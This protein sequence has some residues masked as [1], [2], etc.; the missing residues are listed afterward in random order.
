MFKWKSLQVE[1]S[2]SHKL[3]NQTFGFI[4]FLFSFFQSGSSVRAQAWHSTVWMLGNDSLLL[5]HENNT[6]SLCF[7]IQ[8]HAAIESILPAVGP[9]WR[10]VSSSVFYE[11]LEVEEHNFFASMRRL[12]KYLGLVY[13]CSLGWHQTSRSGLTDVRVQNILKAPE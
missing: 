10:R 13:S 11:G 6:L 5:S 12:F 3:C 7:Q 1:V 9:F 2:L 4:C 8:L